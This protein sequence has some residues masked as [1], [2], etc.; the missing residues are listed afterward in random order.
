MSNENACGAK[1]ALNDLLGGSSGR[2]HAESLL[3]GIVQ[4]WAMD[5]N[6]PADEIDWW[7]G[8]SGVMF[9]AM[10]RLI[11]AKA[12]AIVCELAKMT[13]DAELERLRQDC[14]EAYQVIGAGMLGEPVTYAQA[15]VERALDNLS[16]AANGE[17]RPHE[18]LLPWPK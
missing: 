7:A 2:R 18:D 8:F 6:S 15:D 13:T 9:G 17:P 11:G 1:V 5:S 3:P 16:A 4:A 10:Q 12:N 14:G